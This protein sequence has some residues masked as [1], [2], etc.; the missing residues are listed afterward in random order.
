VSLQ[1]RAHDRLRLP[2]YWFGAEVGVLPAYGHFTGMHPIEP[3]VGDRIY[4]VAGDEVVAVPTP[5]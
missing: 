3:A 4:A 5:R 1:G 2:C